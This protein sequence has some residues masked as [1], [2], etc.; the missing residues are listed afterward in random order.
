VKRLA[1]VLVLMASL[2]G[3][4]AVAG[5]AVAIEL[6]LGVDCS[7]SVNDREYALQMRGIANALRSPAVIAAIGSHD[8]GV[9][10]A[11]F[12]WAGV[13]QDELAVDWRLLRSE[14]DIMAMAAAIE[15]VPSASLG[16]FTAIGQAMAQGLRFL[17]DNGYDGLA[18]RIDISGDGRS[19]SGAEPAAVGTVAALSGVTVNGL[20]VLT[21]DLDLAR[22]YR[23]NVMAGPHGFV[24][25]ARSYDDFERAML[26][27]L[28]R[29][30][31]PALAGPAPANGLR[32][33]A[34]LP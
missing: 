11:L 1:G 5:E 4:P 32:R 9:A 13:P 23:D 2:A 20:A 27:K 21:D 33:T 31:E 30:L 22:Y 34:G 17:A 8:K 14:A 12:L 16:Y 15:A 28:L 7:L 24:E 10:M 6:V 19:N 25:I 18:A 3:Q 26:K 29:E